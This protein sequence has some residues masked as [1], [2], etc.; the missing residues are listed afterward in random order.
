[1]LCFKFQSKILALSIHMNDIEAQTERTAIAVVI[2]LCII[3]AQFSSS[4]GGM[5]I[6]LPALV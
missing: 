6:C 1:M 3:L 2:N 5:S 4:M